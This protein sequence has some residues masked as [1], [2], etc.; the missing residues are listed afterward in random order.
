MTPIADLCDQYADKINVVMPIGFQSFGAKKAFGGAIA[1]IKCF[2]DNSLVKQYL[3][4]AGEQRVLVVDGGGSLRCALVGDNLATLAINNGWAGL[5]V[6]GC[7]RDSAV[8]DTLDVGIKALGTHP[9]KS[10]KKNQGETDIPVTFAG[11]LFTPG[12]FL[13]AD[14][15]GIIVATEKL[16]DS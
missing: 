11:T 3:Q 14:A 1:T 8:I 7:I 5:V 13:Y 9:M 15:D 4:Q 6:Y 2:E 16:I 12:H 10:I